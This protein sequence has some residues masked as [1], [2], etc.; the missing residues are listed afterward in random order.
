MLHGTSTNQRIPVYHFWN[1]WQIE[2]SLDNQGHS[3]RCIIFWQQ[4][5]LKTPRWGL[6]HAVPPRLLESV[7]PTVSLCVNWST[8]LIST[9]HSDLFNYPSSVAVILA[10]VMAPETFW[11][12]IQGCNVCHKSKQFKATCLSC[13]WTESIMWSSD[14]CECFFSNLML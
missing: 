10:N 7:P 14:A 13:K 3:S 1:K 8:C 6:H 2:D 12:H 9:L 4:R 11:Q 5:E